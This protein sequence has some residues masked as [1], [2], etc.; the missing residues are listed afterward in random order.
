VFCPLP[1]TAT[2]EFLHP[3][4]SNYFSLHS[5]SV[6][7]F[8]LCFTFVSLPL[9]QVRLSLSLAPSSSAVNLF[10]H[11]IIS[12][13]HVLHSLCFTSIFLPLFQVRLSLSLSLPCISV[14]GPPLSLPCIYII[15]WA[16]IATDQHENCLS[17]R[18]KYKKRL[19][20]GLSVYF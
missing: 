13:T 8:S 3:Q 9:F 14:S 17:C 16:I 15:I 7:R 6:S 12:L 20:I 18:A 19:G 1:N 10:F 4:K 5:L 11:L 2:S